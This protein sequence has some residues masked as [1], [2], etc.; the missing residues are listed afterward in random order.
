[1]KLTVQKFFR[2]DGGSTQ[3]KGVTPDIIFP[4][5]WSYIETGEKEEDFPMQWTQIDP[6]PYGQKVY[7]LHNLPKIREKSAYRIKTDPVLQKVNE[8]AERIKQQRD[9]T[10]QTLNLESYLAEDKMFEAED[11]AYEKLF[12]AEVITKLDNL[13]ADIAGIEADESKKARNDEWVKG[14]K[15]DVYLK[16]TLNIMHDMITLK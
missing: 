1:V 3:L 11:D 5:T 7:S 16:E 10:E 13:P 2:V 15:K 8:R 12:E 4:D 6:V 14:V 9:D